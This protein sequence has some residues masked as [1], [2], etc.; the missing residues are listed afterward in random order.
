[1][2]IGYWETLSAISGDGTALTAAARASA[3]QGAGGKQG[4][5]TL[6]PN[7]LRVG[8]V[9]DISAFGRISSVVTTPGTFR[10]DLSFGVGG[11]ASFDTLAIALNI[12]AQTNV[13]F[14]LNAQGIVRSIGN[15]GTIF[16]GGTVS[17]TAFINTAAVATG[18]YTGTIAVPFNTAPVVG[19]AVD[20]TVATILDFNWTQTAATGSMTLHNYTLS[21]RTSTGF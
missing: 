19:A 15:A 13:P 17:S 3:L 7:K 2:S 21:L 9:L 11:T 10:F 5:Y 14:Y 18:P 20:M 12:V 8:D 4:L 16:W 6:A 1:M